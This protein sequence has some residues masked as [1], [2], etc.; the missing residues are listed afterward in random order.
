MHPEKDDESTLRND[1]IKN[2]LLAAATSQEQ[3]SDAKTDNRQPNTTF[4]SEEDEG[5]PNGEE[6][7][8]R[9]LGEQA[10]YFNFDFGQ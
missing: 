8:E 1:T 9:T 6:G 3:L 7:N 5:A 2:N 10:E 4:L